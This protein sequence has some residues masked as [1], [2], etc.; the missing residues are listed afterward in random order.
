MESHTETYIYNIFMFLFMSLLAI[1]SGRI[2]LSPSPLD[3]VDGLLVMIMGVIAVA[4][5]GRLLTLV[6]P[7]PHWDGEWRL[8]YIY[9]SSVVCVCVRQLKPQMLPGACPW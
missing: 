1:S 9:S 2:N 4:R 8:E 3:A 6:P 7:S 5:L